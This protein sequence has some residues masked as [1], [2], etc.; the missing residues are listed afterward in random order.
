MQ[1]LRSY[2]PSNTP[3]ALSQQTISPED[4]GAKPTDTSSFL[5][6]HILGHKTREH[7]PKER[8]AAIDLRIGLCML[9]IEGRKLLFEYITQ[10]LQQASEKIPQPEYQE[11]NQP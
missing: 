8:V 6:P 3:H 4:T 9:G 10:K 11:R 7:I 5:S 2:V 1:E